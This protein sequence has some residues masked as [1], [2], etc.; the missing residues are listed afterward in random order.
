MIFE[1]CFESISL[2]L[3]IFKNEQPMRLSTKVYILKVIPSEKL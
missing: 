2:K 1:N 3:K